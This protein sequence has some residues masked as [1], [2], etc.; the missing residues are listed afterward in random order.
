MQTKEKIMKTISRKLD[1]L[2]DGTSLAIYKEV[3]ESSN[4]DRFVSQVIISYLWDNS[5]QDLEF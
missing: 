5:P 4:G 3:L 1:S 2:I